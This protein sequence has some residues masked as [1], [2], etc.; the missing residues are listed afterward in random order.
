MSGLDRFRPRHPGVTRLF[1]DTSA[2]FAFFR[3][4]SPRHSEATAFFDGV[5]SDALPYRPLY[6]NQHVLGETATFLT[7]RVS[8]EAAIQAIDVL[9]ESRP[10]ETIQMGEDAI[11]ATVATLRRFRDVGIAFTD[12]TIGVQASERNVHHVFTYDGDFETLG[13]TTIPHWPS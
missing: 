2:L 9:S 5:S 7:S 12:H 8:T 6:V 4:E 13:L 1:L 3:E 11:G 10:V